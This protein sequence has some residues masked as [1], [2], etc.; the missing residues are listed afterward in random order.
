MRKTIP[1]GLVLVSSA[2]FFTFDPACCSEVVPLV[3]AIIKGARF[4]RIYQQWHRVR[5]K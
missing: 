1:L 3:D 4:E 2:E 5:N